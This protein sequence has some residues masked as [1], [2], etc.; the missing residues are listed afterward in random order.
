MKLDDPK[1][2]DELAEH[3]ARLRNMTPDAIMSM[4]HSVYYE[5]T[6]RGYMYSEPME[7]DEYI[8]EFAAEVTTVVPGPAVTECKGCCNGMPHKFLVA[9]G[10]KSC[11]TCQAVLC[12]FCTACFT[13]ERNCI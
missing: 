6:G 2:H 8:K 5:P 3:I 11:T 1:I 13:F 4:L 7:V 12:Q 10:V 9:E